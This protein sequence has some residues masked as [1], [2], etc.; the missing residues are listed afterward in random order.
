MK[1]G[2][3]LIELLVVI[4]IIA[5][6][7][8]ILFPVFAKAREKARQTKCT[9][10]LR[11][12]ALAASMWAQ[13][14]EEK[15][16]L[17]TA[18]WSVINVPQAILTC[19]S[20]KTLSNGYVCVNY[21]SGKSLGDIP[22]A[23]AAV[24]AGDGLTVSGGTANIAYRGIDF[25]SRHDKNVILAY[26]DTHVAMKSAAPGT[27]DG[28]MTM[29]M[30]NWFVGS[31][32]TASMSTW[33]NS[34][35]TPNP[36]PGGW[37]PDLAA[38]GTAPT[39]VASSA[40]FNGEPSV[41]FTTASQ[42][43]T[44]TN[45]RLGGYYSNAAT[46]I[47]AYYTASTDCSL[48]INDGGWYHNIYLKGGIVWTH[49]FQYPYFSAT[50]GDTWD[51]QYEYYSSTG[52]NG[53][54]AHVLAFVTATTSSGGTGGISIYLDG[55]KV[56]SRPTYFTIYTPYDLILG[57]NT[58]GSGVDVDSRKLFAGEYAEYVHYARA[59]SASEIADVSLYMKAKYLT[60]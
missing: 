40:N 15:L 57:C 59:L 47:F 7:A 14:N 34:C 27:Y 58:N 24:I 23:S 51:G 20:K 5:I 12:I 38:S 60:P 9:S 37:S 22:N 49:Q 25:E 31:A 21:W 30:E 8:A 10:N 53:V 11:Q 32:A 48:C 43:Y 41:S 3:T 29:G 44:N 18:F 54:G 35:S 33:K 56:L 55:K 13:E 17:A 39:Y 2:F 45:S 42:M 36:Y 26:A 6:L 46:Q 16:P 4:A 50:N 52:T 19:P 28:L 1:R